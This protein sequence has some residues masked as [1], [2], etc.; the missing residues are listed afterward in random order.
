[1]T[2]NGGPMP[3]PMHSDDTTE[4]R[5]KQV[6]ALVSDLWEREVE[7]RLPKELEVQAKNLGA[8]QR[9]RGLSSAAQLLRAR[10]SY[11]LCAPSFRRVGVWAVL[12][13]LADLSENAWRKA[14][15]RASDW[16]AWR[17]SELFAGAPPS[18]RVGPPG[19]GGGPALAREARHARG[20]GGGG[21]GL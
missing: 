13:G 1:M 21:W 4:E 3:S 16:L 17:L 8:L 18:E 19:G 14:L 2:R 20:G 10:L 7:P 12:I 9:K 11:A 6:E 5:A 15:R